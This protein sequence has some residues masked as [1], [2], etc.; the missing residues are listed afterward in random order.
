MI[1]TKALVSFVHVTDVE[2]SIA[3]YAKLGFTVMNQVGTPPNWVWLESHNAQ[4]MLNQASGPIDAGQ[5][6][7]MFYLYFEDIHVVHQELSALGCRPSEIRF[8]F[9]MPHGECRLED[10]DGYVLML[11]QA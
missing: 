11:A 2:R 6:A 3:F 10:P 1:A 4:L 9:Y 8:P 5:Q 7:V